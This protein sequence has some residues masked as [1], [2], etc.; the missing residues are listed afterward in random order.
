MFNEMA[1]RSGTDEM[2][3]DH[4]IQ[5]DGSIKIM[6]EDAPH[7]MKTYLVGSPAVS[8][9]LFLLSSCLAGVCRFYPPLVVAS[10]HCRKLTPFC[11]AE[12]GVG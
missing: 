4:E 6:V 11:D 7:K 10:H 8:A 2:K 5:R 9:L 12:V 1:A 3:N